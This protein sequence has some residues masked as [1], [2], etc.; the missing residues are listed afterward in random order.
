MVTDGTN[1]F[2][3]AGRGFLY[4]VKLNGTVNWYTD[5]EDSTSSLV[6]SPDLQFLISSWTALSNS[7]S[8]MVKQYKSNGALHSVALDTLL[9]GYQDI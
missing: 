1:I 5:Y 9:N 6:L 8:R 2:I 7:E 4:S 3:S